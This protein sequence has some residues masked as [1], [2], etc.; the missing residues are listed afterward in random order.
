MRIVKINQSETIEIFRSQII[1]AAYNP[2]LK[3]ESVVESIKNNFRKIGYLGGIVWNEKSGNLVSGHKRIE[4]LDL[5]NNYYAGNDYRIKV[6]KIN[7][8]LKT[9][10]EQNIYMNNTAAQ[11]QFDY[12]SLANMLPDIDFENTE[13]TELDLD[14]IQV[15]SKEDLE[16]PF[17]DEE[18]PKKEITEEYINK[19]K[20][21]KKNSKE[22]YYNRHDD[23]SNSHV[24]LVF[25]NWDA[26]VAFMEL[27]EFDIDA[28][29]V[30]GEE[31][32]EKLNLF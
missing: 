14:K 29:F 26:K 28:K 10:M 20:D 11:G 27:L 18:K 5:L 15:F 17:K 4:A 19:I 12:E 31:L 25:D 7:V 32:A 13:L 22:N 8:D 3:S 16:N 30:K 9:E 1:F 24:T 6:E 23:L 21:I 2:R